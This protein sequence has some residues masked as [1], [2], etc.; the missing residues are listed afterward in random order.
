MNKF[1]QDYLIP[2]EQTQSYYTALVP[3]AEAISRLQ[4]DELGRAGKKN[5]LAIIRAVFQTGSS[6]KIK[7]CLDMRV[8]KYILTFIQDSSSEVRN[9]ALQ[10]FYE[11][12]KG[13]MDD[14]YDIEG[15]VGYNDRKDLLKEQNQ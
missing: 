6:D 11:I 2:N 15:K 4:S 3:L 7:T 14:D 1:Y 12:S 9:E 10:I 8:P 13:L 5:S